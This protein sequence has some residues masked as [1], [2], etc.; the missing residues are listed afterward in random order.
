MPR[1]YRKHAL[2]GIYHVVTRGNNRQIIF[3]E[4]ADRKRFLRI[5]RECLVSDGFELY[6]YC[7]MNNHIH[8]IIRVGDKD[9]SSV[10]Q[11]I[12][13]RYVMWFNRKYH[14]TGSLFEDRFDSEPIGNPLYLKTAWR[15]VL[16]N[17]M[18]AGL[19]DQPGQKYLWT[20]I[21]AYLSKTDG[22]TSVAVVCSC[23]KDRADMMHFLFEKVDTDRQRMNIEKNE[24]LSD[25]DVLFLMKEI[26]G[27]QSASEFCR[28]SRETRYI[29]LK[30]MLEYP[31]NI[32]Q[33][34]RITGVSR[35][36]ITRN[37]KNKLN[38]LGS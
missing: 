3:E 21:D 34:S 35:S 30:R 5:L 11:K 17:P 32:S 13:S 16:Q 18:R 38:K 10:C 7:L 22:F 28:F 25:D 29:Y 31:V 12:Q 26:T 4:D 14:R 27:C 8:L 37:L 6:A 23:F 15:Y 2:T 36:A 9:L 33:L 1:R 24:R 19:E 20:D